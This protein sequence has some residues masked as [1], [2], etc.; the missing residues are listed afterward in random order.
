AGKTAEEEIPD[1]REAQQRGKAA[2]AVIGAWLK[3]LQDALHNEIQQID[4]AA[5]RL[6]VDLESEI[7]VQNPSTDS[8]F[9]S[10]CEY[11]EK[12]LRN[13][14][15]WLEDERLVVF[16]EYK[17]TLDY[18]LR[19]LRDQFEGQEDRI[20]SL[21]GGMDDAERESIKDAFNN[22]DSPVRMLIATD[23]A[24]EGL[25]LQA[26]ARY[27][28]HY[29]CPWNPSR[30]EQRN[31]RLDRHGQAR[32]VHIFHFASEQDADLK[33]ISYL[34]HKVDQMREDLGSMGEI[35]DEATHRRLIE[36]EE[37]TTV[38]NTLDFLIE[39]NK[40]A[41][42][43]DADDSVENDPQSGEVE[44]ERKI[45]AMAAELDIDPLTQRDT[46]EAAMA[47]EHGHPQLSELDDLERFTIINPNLFGWKDTIDET[48]RKKTTDRTLGPIPKLSF[49]AKPFI[50]KIGGRPVFRPRV[51]TLMLHQGHPLMQKAMGVLTRRRFPA[52]QN[53]I[54]RWTVSYGDIPAGA[55]AL[56]LLHVEELGV[57]ELRETFHH[58]IQTYQIPVSQDELGKPLP[59]AP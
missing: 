45:D 48:I 46:L 33:F 13:N 18:L 17:T 15:Q 57:N 49:S 53:E 59:H 24:S 1:D 20:L 35:F 51:D 47:S 16:T 39:N 7:L 27:L 28:L 43:I 6:G 11:I 40:D 42:Q 41:A 21:Y 54:S 25:N 4:G 38:Q 52:T 12:L 44:F 2:S 8:R 10:L 55:D 32:D 22:P 58:W 37:L 30:L 34:I 56:L 29:D 3:P 31:G 14:G 36:G 5:D 26:A 23:A 9:D 19:R 50:Q